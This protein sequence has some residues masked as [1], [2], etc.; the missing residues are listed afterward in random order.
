[1]AHILIVDDSPTEIH[2]IKSIL[3][4]T[5]H[6]VSFATNG[7]EG[8]S[9]TKEIMPDL[10]LMDVVMPGLNG[11]Q[12][13][14]E[15]SKTPETAE[16]PVIIVTTKDQESDRVWGLRQ[17]AKE[18]VTKPVEEAELMAKVSALIG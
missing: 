4:K 10:V 13:T 6:E 9:K 16:I 17:G 2:V 11:F 7:E 1:M 3:E 14:R 12:A 18:Y 8:V 5:G 15:L